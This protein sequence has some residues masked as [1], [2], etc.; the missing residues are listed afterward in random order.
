MKKLITKFNAFIAYNLGML[1]KRFFWKTKKYL[2]IYYNNLNDLP[3]NQKK[4]LVYMLDGRA[5]SGGI[6]DILKGILSMYQFSK[7]IE[8]DFRINFCYPYNL[9]DYLEPN[10]YNWF[11]SDNEISYNSNY[12]LPLW[13][14]SS[15]SK[16]GKSCEFE[17]E[18]QR[19][20]LQKFFKKNKSKLQFHI[21]TNSEWIKGAEY[22]TLF[23]ELFK[24]SKTVQDTLNYHKRYLSSDYISMT[25]RFQQLLGDFEN[26]DFKNDI[27]NDILT[28]LIEKFELKDGLFPSHGEIQL[29]AIL[30]DFKNKEISVPLNEI[31]KNILIDRCIN[32]IIEIQN[33]FYPAMK[34]L[35]TADSERFLSEV[36]KLKF[37][38]EISVNR[39]SPK[40]NI[41]E[42]YDPFQK[43]YI[44]ILMLSESQK[45]HLLCS[46]PMYLSGFAKNASFINNRIY[47]EVIF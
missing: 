28:L 3:T 47:Q 22:S 20:I 26:M 25:F 24:P 32:K 42:K 39:I 36:S 9:S 4:I 7:E 40:S 21:Y 12:S 6:S 43:A 5:Y 41:N 13:I 10:L 2:S 37:V 14:Y 11:I 18:F 19:K 38:Y 46:G 29:R 33:N 27:A 31:D 15:Y 1:E 34:V 16:F 45:L 30:G 35:I 44:D 8:F 23:N 17:I